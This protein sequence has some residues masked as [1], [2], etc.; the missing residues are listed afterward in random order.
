MLNKNQIYKTEITGLTSEGN[1]V[2]H[3]NSIAVFVP[4]TAVGDILN[5]RIVK[6]LKKYAFGIVENIITPSSDRITSDCPISLKCGGCMFRHISYEAE[7]NYKHQRVYDAITRIGG[8]DG[9]LVGEIIPSD[10]IMAYR[11]K[12]QLP[13]AYDKNGNVTVGFFAQ[14]S[15]RVISVDNCLLHSE[16]F[17][18]IID[19]F[20]DFANEYKLTPYDEKSHSGLLRHLYMRHAMETDEIMVCIVINGKKLPHENELCERLIAVENRIKTIVININC[21][22]TNVITGKEC[23]TIFGSGYITDKLCGLSFRISPLSFY[24]VN[25]SQAEK[26]YTIARDFAELKPD[27]TLLDLYCGTGTIGLTMADS[28][29][30]LYGVEIIPQA[31]EDAKINAEINNIKNAEF[32]CGD[33]SL[34]AEKLAQQGIKAD[35][36]IIDPPRKGCDSTLI[37]TI[38]EKF[39][40]PRVIYISCD[41]ATLARDLKIF[42]ELGYS[43]FKVIPVDLFPRTGHVETV[44]M[45]SHKK[46]DSVINVK[47]E[48]GEGEGKVPLDNIAKRAAAYKPKERVTYKMI[49]EYIEAKYGFKVHTAYIAEVKRDLGLPM[50]DA[51]NAVE[52]LKQPRKHPTPEKVEAI[53]DALKH[54]EVI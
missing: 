44:V 20:T 30:R 32:F 9:S 37:N 50:Y 10:R 45:L 16:A 6:V 18:P 26:L 3:I 8:I 47:V 24:Q 36:I 2:C 52:E 7:L 31:I 49:K 21:D 46:P 11:N 53:K 23:R 38:S 13:I 19:C 5:V 48:F 1:G 29:K 25:R 17:N 43:A 33:A 35:C 15:H 51:P 28:V 42:N 27:E 12:A 22:K 14:R 34:A 4:N 39:S 41:P 40:P 54:F